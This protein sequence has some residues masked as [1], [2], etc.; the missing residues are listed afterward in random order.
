MELRLKEQKGPRHAP[1]PWSQRV[2]DLTWEASTLPG[3]EWVGQS[4]S[5][6][7]PLL[8]EDP[9]HLPRLNS[10]RPP[11]YAPR[12]NV[13]GGRW[14]GLEGRGP[15]CELSRLRRPEWVRQ[16]PSTPLPF[17]PAGS[18]HLPLLVSPASV[19][20]YN[21]IILV[22]LI[23]MWLSL[24]MILICISL[25]IIDATYLGMCFFAICISTISVCLSCGH[26]GGGHKF[27][28]CFLINLCE[29]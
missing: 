6:P 13:A 8:P 2:G 21:F 10:P 5:T 27:F 24:I 3:L 7:L 29:S 4:P 25:K 22:I 14:G 9:S 1:H 28:F 16:T 18:F 11:S 19:P 26:F 12:T 17:L 20:G 15:A 23:C